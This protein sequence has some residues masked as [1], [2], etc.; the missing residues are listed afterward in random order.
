[1]NRGDCEDMIEWIKEDVFNEGDSTMYYIYI[2]KLQDMVNHNRNVL[3][4]ASPE[5]YELNSDP[6]I[7]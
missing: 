7:D 3:Y 5:Y 4:T 2:P 1:M 6:I